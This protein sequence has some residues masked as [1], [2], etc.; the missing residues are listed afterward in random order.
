MSLPSHDSITQ[1]HKLMLSFCGYRPSV[2]ATPDCCALKLPTFVKTPILDEPPYFWLVYLISG[3]SCGLCRPAAL[4]G[5][6]NTSS[7]PRSN[8]GPIVLFGTTIG[9]ASRPLHASATLESYWPVPFSNFSADISPLVSKHIPF[10][11]FGR[12][13]I[14]KSMSYILQTGTRD[15]LI[16]GRVDQRVLWGNP[17]RRTL[18][19]Y[20]FWTSFSR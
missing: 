7:K 5:I 3:S 18:D 16:S 12:R 8:I 9:P 2:A 11:N 13:T 20:S 14:S 6:E 15:A 4:D 19:V 10:D 17:R 1:Y